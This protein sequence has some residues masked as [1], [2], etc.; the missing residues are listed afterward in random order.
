MRLLKILTTLICLLVVSPQ[1]FAQSESLNPKFSFGFS[2]GLPTSVHFSARDIGVR[3]LEI[4]ADA[5]GI[6]FFL[7]GYAQLALN[8]EY[9]F[10]E[11]REVGFY[12]GLGLV[13]LKILVAGE[14]SD[15]NG[16]PWK[17]GG[18]GYVGI[19]LGP[20]FIEF[21]AMQLID[22]ASTGFLGLFPRVVLGFHGYF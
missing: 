15:P 22:A 1:A 13:A 8:L 10:A 17:F 21:G 4:R 9:H 6:L 3:G 12:F 2:I 14:F 5:G 20:M 7:F 11:P 19:D 18:Q 16:Y